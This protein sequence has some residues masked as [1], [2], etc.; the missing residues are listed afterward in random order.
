M[1]E[2]R[3][4]AI[5]SF[6]SEDKAYPAS[7]LLK[8]NAF[9][10]WK[11][12]QAGA[13]HASVTFK[14]ACPIQFTRLDIGNEASA[15]ISV[16]VSRADSSAFELLLPSSSFMSPADAKKG[17]SLNRVRIFSGSELTPS[18]SCQKWDIVRVNCTQPFNTE[19]QYGLAFIRFYR[20][21]DLV[22]VTP[23]AATEE[24]ANSSKDCDELLK[25]GGLF[26]LA[27][28]SAESEEKS[29]ITNVSSIKAAA[30]ATVTQKLLQANRSVMDPQGTTALATSAASVTS[31]PSTST[32]QEVSSAAGDTSTMAEG[33]ARAVVKGKGRCIL[34]GVV[35]AFS[36]YKNPFRSELR[37]MCLRLGAKYRQD[38]TDD[39]THLICAFPNTP[40]WNAVKGRGI[41]TSHKWI[42]ACNTAQRRVSWRPYRVGRAPSP[43]GHV[44]DGNDDDVDSDW[45]DEWRPDGS[46]Q[47]DEE[48]D[49]S[50][51]SDVFEESRSEGEENE[52]EDDSDRGGKSK[53]PRQKRRRI[54]VL[55]QSTS[56]APRKNVEDE[57]TD[58]E[59]QRNL[60]NNATSARKSG[61]LPPLPDY[62]SGRKFFIFSRDLD[63]NEGKTVY[64]LIIAF[65]GIIEPHMSTDVEFVVSR[66]AWCDEFDEAL[67]VS[68]SLTFVKPEW[69]YACDRAGKMVPF[70][71]YQ[72]VG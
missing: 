66:A 46:D 4:E 33:G 5:L 56:K 1:P 65:G 13:K 31:T 57:D 15:F 35:V 50:S 58:E 10:K 3:P 36:G 37:E 17:V 47:D 69:I 48:R 38:W 22:D 14:F 21:P 23:T 6:S 16:E 68:S 61:S 28:R 11:C 52:N 71:R 59:I 2:V 7:N 19:F 43:V 18:I 8:V 30:F 34:D 55:T 45:D 72:I 24:G 60:G 9:S 26:R 49:E 62:F 51:G 40:K 29:A 41:I 67:E 32:A 12:Q 25:P 44:S 64:R 54:K 27:K 53:P 42:Q 39:C 63:V 70:Q 20:T